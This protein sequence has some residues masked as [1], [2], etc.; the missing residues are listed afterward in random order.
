MNFF[1]K[2]KDTE[3]RMTCLNIFKQIKNLCSIITWLISPLLTSSYFMV[4]SSASYFQHFVWVYDLILLILFFYKE[5][6]K[7]W[8]CRI[9][10]LNI[11][12]VISG[13]PIILIQ[14]VWP[15][16]W[17]SSKVVEITEFWV[18][19]WVEV[20]EKRDLSHTVELIIIINNK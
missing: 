17:Y 13:K 15:L 8:R 6:T 1:A 20:W 2:W 4:K 19:I 3:E 9:T 16:G 5:E 10:C 11:S 7:A 18:K 12:N 14:T